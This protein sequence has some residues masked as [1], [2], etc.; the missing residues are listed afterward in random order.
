MTTLRMA[1]SANRRIVEVFDD[2]GRF[3]AAI[4]PTRKGSNAIHIVSVYSKETIIE[5]SDGEIAIPGHLVKFNQS[6][7]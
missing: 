2:E 6:Q 1:W 5:P 3:V 7:K 4:Y